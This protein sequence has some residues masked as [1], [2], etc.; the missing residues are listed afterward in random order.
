VS[1][2]QLLATGYGATIEYLV[3]G[4]GTPEPVT[5]FAH[6][7]GGSIESTRPLGSGVPGRKVFF[8]FRGY[9]GSS[10]PS[11]ETTLDDLADDL[12]AVADHVGADRALGAS[13]GAAALCTLLTRQPDRFARLVFYLPAWAQ[14]DLAAVGAPA[15][16]LACHDD[17]EHPVSEAEHLADVLGNATLYV[18]DRPDP[19]QT[20]RASLR[21]RI[22]GFLGG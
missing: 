22:A 21:E 5:V 10:V 9:G 3:A 17:P 14:Y 11:R 7:R 2:T 12:A 16:V 6:G 18:F 1:R 19:V 15:L 13:M 4:V 8:H 20:A